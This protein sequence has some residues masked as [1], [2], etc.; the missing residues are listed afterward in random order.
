M[1]TKPNTNARRP[2]VLCHN[3]HKYLGVDFDSPSILCGRLEDWGPFHKFKFKN[4]SF[5]LSNLQKSIQRLQYA[6]NHDYK[7]DNSVGELE[8]IK[9]CSVYAAYKSA[10]GKQYSSNL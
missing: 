9:E 1:L 3:S 8:M 6:N 5:G 7:T 4:I 2:D 10:Y